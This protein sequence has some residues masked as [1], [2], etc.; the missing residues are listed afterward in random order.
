MELE[1]HVKFITLFDFLKI[2]FQNKGILLDSL[3]IGAFCYIFWAKGANAHFGPYFSHLRYTNLSFTFG[4]ESFTH[5]H[6]GVAL[7]IFFRV[8]T[9]KLKLYKI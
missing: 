8:V 4:K 2:K 9:K 3:K 7:G 6:S 5:M 1:F